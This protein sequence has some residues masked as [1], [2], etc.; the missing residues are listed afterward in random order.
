MPTL[1]VTKNQPPLMAK[2]T[3]FSQII[4]KIPRELVKK[5]V[6][7]HGVD[8]HCKGFNSWSHLVSMI[9]CQFADCV[10]LREISNG[11]HSANGNLNHLGISRAPSKS[12]LSYQNEKRSCEFFR[13]SYYALLNYFGQQVRFSGRKFRFK[14]AVKLLDSSTITL[15][16]QVFDWA[17]YTRLKGAIKLH[18]LLNFGTLLPDYM[19]ITDGSVGD[20]TA[21]YQ[22]ELARGDIVVCDRGYFDTSLFS[23]WDSKG[24]FFVVRVKDNMLYERIKE[25]DLPDR[26]HPEVLIDEI[27]MLTGTGTSTQYAKPIRRI[28]V[29][30]AE[31]GFTMELLTNNFK[32]AA[33]TIA[34]LYRQRWKVETFFRTIKQNFHIKSFIG[35]SRNAVEIQIWTALI[36]ILLLAVLKQQATY[37][38]HFSNLVS[39]LRL[40]TFTKIDLHLWLNHPFSPPPDE[41]NTT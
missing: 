35:T 33:G 3:L 34:D 2:V 18:T 19:H 31:H 40:N 29:Y 16:A 23:Y 10:S 20:N 13:D 14:N 39:S 1:V 12:N 30:N 17:H 24:V 5:L 37:K 26:A 22:I 41:E 36:T 6:K 28:A 38:W 4:S 15:C 7:R 32:L 9:F 21:A 8:K 25:L 27:V 11:L